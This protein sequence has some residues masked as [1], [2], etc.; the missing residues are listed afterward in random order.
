MPDRPS[1]GDRANTFFALVPP[2]AVRERIAELQRQLIPHL[3]AS[4]R[5]VPPANFHLTLAFLGA[6]PAASLPALRS[7]A[8]RLVPPDADLVLDHLGAFPRARVGWLGASAV[9]ERLVRFQA[10]L[11]ASL[12]D[13]GFAPERRAW[14]PHL[15]LFRRLRGTLPMQED[16]AY[17][18]RVR[19]F[20]LLRTVQ[21]R[22]GVRYRVEEHWP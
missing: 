7:V 18:W 8:D 21:G 17:P 20:V 15:T 19:T 12:D 5:P 9:D 4:V 13:A 1:D 14:V 6:V 16:L 3:P 11:A 2:D 22:D 10:R